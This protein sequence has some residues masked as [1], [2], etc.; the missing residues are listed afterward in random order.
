MHSLFS[1]ECFPFHVFSKCHDPPYIVAIC[2]WVSYI[3]FLTLGKQG[4]CLT[5]H[6]LTA[7][8]RTVDA[9]GLDV[10]YGGH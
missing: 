7:V 2:I 3:G 10:Q 5:H 6:C 8:M 1:L 9:R 4:L